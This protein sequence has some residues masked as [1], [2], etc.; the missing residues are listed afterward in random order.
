MPQCSAC[1]VPLTSTSRFCSSCGAAQ[2]P[3]LETITLVKPA[4]DTL[5][6]A[7]PTVSPGRARQT[8][9][10]RLHLSDALHQA[11]FLPGMVVV[12]R[13]RIVGLLGKGGMGE[14][15]RADDLKL[16]RPWRSNSC[17]SCWDPAP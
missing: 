1:S 7:A 14:V 12:D 13:Y 16:G 3:S 10:G 6:S 15:Y 4:A 2:D 11:R 8:A 9:M 5:R 17:P